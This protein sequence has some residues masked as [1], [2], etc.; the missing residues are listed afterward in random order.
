MTDKKDEKTGNVTIGVTASGFPFPL[1][2]QWEE[3][4]KKRFN[5]L[6]WAKMWSDHL[7]AQAMRVL[8]E[9]LAEMEARLAQLEGSPAT[10]EPEVL[11]FGG[12]KNE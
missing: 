11:T 10:D 7:E 3:D 2:K 9:K 1:F 6:R 8:T 12:D 5:N 4:C